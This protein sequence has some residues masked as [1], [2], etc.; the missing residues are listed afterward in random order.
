M[1][2]LM[3]QAIYSMLGNALTS[4]DTDSAEERTHKIFA[5]MD[6]N[7]DGVLTRAE[8]VDGCMKDQFLYQMLTADAGGCNNTEA[9]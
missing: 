2:Y 6:V 5:K 1:A 9:E 4:Q 3:L 8:F 7:N